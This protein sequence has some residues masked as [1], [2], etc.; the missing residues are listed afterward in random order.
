MSGTE[1]AHPNTGGV[2]LAARE[3]GGPSVVRL[4]VELLRV[5]WQDGV[6]R[7]SVGPWANELRRQLSHRAGPALGPGALESVVDACM[8]VPFGL[9]TLVRSLEELGVG[10]ETTQ[11]VQHLADEWQALDFFPQDEWEALRTL[12]MP[13]RH[14]GVPSLVHRALGGRLPVDRGPRAG[15]AWQAMVYLSALNAP[16]V[17]PPPTLVFLLLLAFDDSTR[18]LLGERQCAQLERWAGDWAERWDMAEEFTRLR[19]QVR[20][21]AAQ[22]PAGRAETVLVVQLAPHVRHPERYVLSHWV[23]SEPGARSSRQGEDR[24]VSLPQIAEVLPRILDEVA[25]EGAGD[26]ARLEFILP[27]ELLNS[28]VET[29]AR[30][31][32]PLPLPVAYPVVVRS[33]ERMHN[34]GHHRVWRHRWQQLKRSDSPSRIRWNSPGEAHASARLMAALRSDEELVGCVLSAPPTEANR[35]AFQE[36]RLALWEGLPILLW[37]REDCTRPE[38][39]AMVTALLAEGNLTDL[40]RRIE[41]LHQSGYVADHIVVLFDD[42]DRLPETHPA[43]AS[44]W[45]AQ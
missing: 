45:S 39:R 42:P 7:S 3:A 40:P 37:D 11:A 29:W 44:P 19:Q 34:R 20:E 21:Q 24:V 31:S 23:R 32:G 10:P 33:L 43:D 36:C 14:T 30:G 6:L 2:P 9:D 38:F 35:D 26:P 1:G 15:T 16:P 41:A 12:L 25:L 5:L 13:V 28:P 8:R 4:R 22:D 17:G 27:L 18:L